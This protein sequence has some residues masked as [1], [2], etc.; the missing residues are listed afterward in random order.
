M[1]R[2]RGMKESRTI[3][4]VPSAVQDVVDLFVTE[5]ASLKFGDLDPASLAAASEEVRALA[6]DVTRA[7]A[8]LENTRACLADKRDALVQQAQRAL[9]YARVY[10]ENQPEL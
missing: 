3:E 1:I 6:A 4:P 2:C 5:L 10:A 8:A 9:A 7:E